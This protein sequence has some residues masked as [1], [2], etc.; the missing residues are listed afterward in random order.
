MPVTIMS[1]IQDNEDPPPIKDKH[2]L[3]YASRTLDPV[4]TLVDRAREIQAAGDIVT[5]HLHGKLD[6]IQKQIQSL[7][8]QAMR[9]LDESQE[10][11]RLHKVLCNFE[12]IIGQ[13]MHLY[14][15]KTGDLYFSLL[16]LSDWKGNPP[17]DFLNTYKLQPDRSYKRM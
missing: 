7:Q 12:K 8:K 4:I 17:H 5:G 10:N 6:L 2:L 13:E 9:L 15:K 14:R 16:S 3:A 1:E 11:M